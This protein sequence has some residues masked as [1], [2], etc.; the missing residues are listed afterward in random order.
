MGRALGSRDPGA[1]PG[2]C[3]PRPRALGRA[4]QVRGLGRANP[5]ARPGSREPRSR[6]SSAFFFFFSPSC[7]VFLAGAI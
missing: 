6:S 1:A 3:D 4:T 5:G 7:S 2:S